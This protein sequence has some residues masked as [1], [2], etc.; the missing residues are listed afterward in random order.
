[1]IQKT[2][3]R[4]IL[5]FILVA[6]GSSFFSAAKANSDCRKQANKLAEDEARKSSQTE[7]KDVSKIQ[8]GVTSNF[9]PKHSVPTAIGK[10]KEEYE[11]EI[12]LDE[13]ATIACYAI[14]VKK[15]TCQKISVKAIACD[16]D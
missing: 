9:I 13:E 7:K 1:M 10:D 3:V 6:S 14:Q 2:F 12:V 16:G 8:A 4:I 11:V 15:S 5:V